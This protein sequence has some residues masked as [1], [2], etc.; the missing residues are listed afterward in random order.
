MY[1]TASRKKIDGRPMLKL[2]IHDFEE[3]DIP[4]LESIGVDQIEE[5]KE[6]IRFT[7]IYSQE[8]FLDT[9]ATILEKYDAEEIGPRVYLTLKKT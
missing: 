7:F 5:G 8:A 9:R 4:F 2:N 1:M 3:D 6:N